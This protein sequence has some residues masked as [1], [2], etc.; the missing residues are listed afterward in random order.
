MWASIFCLRRTPLQYNV[1]V[2]GVDSEGRT[3]KGSNW[4]LPPPCPS[5]GRTHASPPA[6]RQPASQPASPHSPYASRCLPRRRRRRPPPPCLR[7]RYLCRF[8]GYGA[9][10]DMWLP[11]SQITEVAMAAWRSGG[12]RE[13]RQR[14][15]SQPA[16]QPVTLSGGCPASGEE[17]APGAAH[18]RRSRRRVGQPSGAR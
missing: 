14:V 11:A 8:E 17:P 4:L 9:D 5:P 12:Q 10:D 1:T 13:W 3:T 2:M 6:R 16:S 15:A 18:V 7:P